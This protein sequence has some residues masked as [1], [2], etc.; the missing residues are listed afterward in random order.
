MKRF[1]L[2]FLCFFTFFIANAQINEFG[3][4]LG[5]SNFIGDVGAT[6]YIKPNELAFGLLY[7]WNQS[8]R[9]AWRLSYIHSNL[10]AKDSESDM[11]S[12]IKRNL[13]FENSINEFSLGLE[14][15][16]FDFKLDDLDKRT[17]PYVMTGLN[18]FMYDSLYRNGNS[19]TIDESSSSFSIPMAVGIKS[20]ISISL[21]L[22]LEVGVRYSFVDDI[23]GSNPKN[24]AYQNQRF[25]NLD[26]NDWYTF[27]GATLTYTFGNKPCYCF[28]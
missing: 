15:N 24:D 23:D 13:S 28:N 19:I 25:G 14:F 10:S 22:A 2:T 3:V 11:Q 12:R 18:Y 7:K 21:V 27:S 26:N 4:F 20:R 8:T 9:H 16:F 5:G 1:F 17:T 6:N